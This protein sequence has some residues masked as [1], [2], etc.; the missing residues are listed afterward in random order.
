MNQSASVCIVC[1]QPLA[2]KQSLFCSRPCKSRR[3]NSVHQT[4]ERQLHR[5]RTLKRKLILMLG[6]AC[7]RC[8]YAQNMAALEFHHTDPTQKSFPLDARNLANRSW[9]VV[10]LEASKCE[11]LCSNCH[12]E[13]HNPGWPLTEIP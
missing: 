7:H 8:G 3:T 10:A 9:S 13:H 1:G 6:G 5:A 4:Y 2:G 12:A 11:L